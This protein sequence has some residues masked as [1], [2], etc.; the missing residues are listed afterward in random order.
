[1]NIGKSNKI[2][3]CNYTFA[4]ELPPNGIP[5]DPLPLKPLAH[6]FVAFGPLPLAHSLAA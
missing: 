4:I 2:F 5:F 1:M 3:D 6:S